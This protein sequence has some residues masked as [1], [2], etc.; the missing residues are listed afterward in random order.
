MR[1]LRHDFG[2]AVRN[3]FRDEVQALLN[4]REKNAIE[5]YTRDIMLVGRRF[6]IGDATLG[7]VVDAMMGHRIMWMMHVHKP[8]LLLMIKH[9]LQISQLIKEMEECSQP[10][11]EVLAHFAD[12]AEANPAAFVKARFEI[13]YVSEA[14]STT[15]LRLVRL[16]PL[17]AFWFGEAPRSFVME[18][19]ER[20]PLAKNIIRYG[21]VLE[22]M[23]E[24]DRRRLFALV[25]GVSDGLLRLSGDGPLVSFFKIAAALPLELQE[26]LVHL[27]RFDDEVQCQRYHYMR[28]TELLDEV[29]IPRLGNDMC[30]YFAIVERV[31]NTSDGEFEAPI[32]CLREIALAGIK[33]CSGAIRL[34]DCDCRWMLA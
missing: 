6:R 18:V 24:L 20:A 25:V 7:A 2:D 21:V 17:C 33:V 15:W 3:A 22:C 11:A 27:A 12:C 28:M 31:M 4:E 8:I 19:L 29:K 23:A 32:T 14:T 16:F 10:D 13:S 5:T 1:W 30:R 34:K 9:G 26:R